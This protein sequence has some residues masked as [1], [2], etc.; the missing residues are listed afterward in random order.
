MV[1][2]SWIWAAWK[3]YQR[4]ESPDWP[5]TDGTVTTTKVVLPKDSFFGQ[6]KNQ[7]TYK[8][9]LNYSYSVEGKPYSGLYQCDFPTEGEAREFIRDLVGQGVRVQYHPDKSKKSF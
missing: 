6:S 7:Q 9:A 8:A 5:V 1:A 3:R 4:A 2:G